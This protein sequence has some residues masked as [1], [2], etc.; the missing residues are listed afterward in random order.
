MKAKIPRAV[1]GIALFFLFFSY[2]GAG[3]DLTTGLRAYYPFNGNVNDA[4]GN[5]YNG[6]LIN[7]PTLTTDK[8]GNPNGAYN[9]DGIDDYIQIPTSTDIS[10]TDELSVAMYFYPTRH[11][12]AT[13]VGKVNYTDGLGIQF[14]AAMDFSLYPGIMFG[15]NAAATGC[16]GIHLNDSYTNSGTVFALNQWHC[17]VA[18]FKKGVHKLYVDGVLVSTVNAGFTDL[19]QCPH[20]AIQIGSWWSGNP[21]FFQGKIDEV[22]I[23]DR[24]LSAADAAAFCPLQTCPTLAGTLTGS[25]TCNNAP[26]MLTFHSSPGTGTGPFTISYSDGTNVYSQPNVKDGEPFA[27]QVQPTVPTV[28]TLQSIQDNSG[29]APTTAPPGVTATI[30]PGSCSLCT[31]ALGDPIVN[32][33]FGTGPG[34]S[35]PLETAVPGATTINLTYVPV[36]G[37]PALPTPLDGQYTITNNVPVN[38]AWFSGAADHTPNDVDGY[39]L[40]A[41]AG[42]NPGEFFRQKVTNLCG[43]GKYEFAAWFGNADNPAVLNAILPDLT[44]IVQTEDGTVLDAYNSGPVPQSSVWTWRQYGFF[45]TLPSG[46]STVV[47]RI[48]D[49]NPGGTAQPGNDFAIDDI[50]FRP[51]GPAT[52]SSFSAATPLT[53]L[54]ICEGGGATLYGTLSAGYP[55]PQYLWQVSAD[56]G[57][58]WTDIPNSNAVQLPVTAPV[59]GQAVDY[60]YRMLAADGNNIQ[61]PACRVASNVSILTTRALP[62]ADFVFIQQVCS[63]LQVKFSGVA[64][65]GL[66]Y[67]WNIEGVDH[68]VAGSPDL[69]YIFTSPGTYPVMLKITDGTCSNS[70]MKTIAVQV[71]PS[72]LIHTGDTTLCAGLPVPLS[73]KPVLEFCWSPTDYLDNPASPSPVATPPV[74]T[75]YYFTARVTGA[76][77]VANGDFSAGNTGFTS[78]Y[79]YTQVNQGPA[80]YLVGKN[81]SIWNPGM[82]ACTDHTSGA[83]NMLMING[84][85]QPN[86]NVWSQTV[87]VTPNTDY[88]FSA[89]LENITTVNPSILQFSINGHPLGNLLT[90]N[91]NSCVWDQYYTVWNSGSNTTAVISIVNQNMVFSGND[92]ALDDISF[93]PVALQR[94][95]VTITVS[96]LPD[97]QAR[98]DTSVCPGKSV[99]LQVTGAAIYSWTP[100]STLSDPASASPVATPDVTTEYIVKG[101]SLEGCSANDTIDVALYYPPYIRISSDT[102]ICSGDN[103]HLHVEAGSGASFSWLPVALLDDPTSAAPVGTL[104][105]DTMFRVSITDG[106]GCI[107]QDSV[108]VFIRPAPVF[109]QPLDLPVCEGFSGVLGR[110]D[111]IHY[112]YSWSP[113]TDLDDASSPRPIVTPSASRQYTVHI[114]DS[115]CPRYNS[116]FFVN[117]NVKPNPV[118]KA[119]KAHDIDC[120]QPT[121]Q[122]NA[123]GGVTYSW[124][125]SMGLSDT[126]SANP[127]VSIDSTMKYY[128]KGTAFDECYAYDS[129]TVHVKN[130]GPNLFV[131]PNAFTPNGDGHNDC[132]GIQRWGEVEVEEFSVFNRWGVRVFTTRNPAQCWDGNFN[133]HPQPAGAYV[134][135]IRAK[136]FCGPVTRMGNLT[137]VR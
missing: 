1:S 54:K 114:S 63:P 41:N 70:A 11:Q 64:Q 55:N 98:P 104:S 27:V 21:L 47:I 60:Y 103:I 82:F 79:T 95:S 84:A 12:V 58:T 26:G 65:S 129:V 62:N 3:Q 121:T 42:V 124:F 111:Y 7:G 115:T 137:L 110:N 75:K 71:Q 59:T 89:W 45:F 131:V 80:E 66:T 107:E 39:M 51:C 69:P 30:N 14:Q 127:V 120:S 28:Y 44:F 76:N 134:Y 119:S 116:D 22:R 86:V 74:T 136:T 6:V 90:A 67:T 24:E 112:V 133:G 8:A 50:T 122:L 77:L 101:T 37:N 87:T 68:I 52:T 93:S 19:N 2:S 128:V 96:P 38:G 105:L 20:G 99:P 123:T 132:Y 43:G 56:S 88:A 109:V 5:G 16:A 108:K 106:N 49:N 72:E 78:D 118:V 102:A 130:I 73:T 53:Q 135:V 13:M 125:P 126:S 4:T 10:P 46:V 113:A 31:G 85:Q 25:N 18:T 91:V 40:F 36:S 97:V 15:V 32:V 9:F 34:N 100:A 29:C 83:G 35:P 94:D 33:D 92:F 23:Y 57:K 17:F 61:S 48:L 117:V 81:P